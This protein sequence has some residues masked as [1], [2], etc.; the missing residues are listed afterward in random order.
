[1][2]ALPAPLAGGLYSTGPGRE[3]LSSIALKTAIE[4]TR[5]R[6]L[7]RH[8]HHLS[9]RKDTVELVVLQGRES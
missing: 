7:R 3:L 6:T 5:V 2:L 9:W 1:M 8:K 4:V